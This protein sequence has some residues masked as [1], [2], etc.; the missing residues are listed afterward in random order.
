MG[1]SSLPQAAHSWLTLSFAFCLCVLCFL[2][3]VPRLS[4]PDVQGE[5]VGTVQRTGSTSP[6]GWVVGGHNGHKGPRPACT[7]G[8]NT[9]PVGEGNLGKTAGLLRSV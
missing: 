8:E 4:G 9:V 1:P 3:L 5:L 2:N 7:R 6:A